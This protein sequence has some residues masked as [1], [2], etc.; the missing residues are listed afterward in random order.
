MILAAALLAVSSSALP[1]APVAQPVPAAVEH[2]RILNRYDYALYSGVIATRLG[3]YFTTESFL[4]RGYHEGILPSALV[5]SRPG[6]LAYSL[7]VSAGEI[8]S[9]YWL[10]SKGHHRIARVLDSA[11]LLEIGINDIL[12]V[13]STR[14]NLLTP[15]VAPPL[16]PITVPKRILE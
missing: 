12:N 1:P 3:D 14:R 7:G 6:F 11:A 13:T 9:S 5:E 10:H 15:P 2:K 16:S 8:A 4:S